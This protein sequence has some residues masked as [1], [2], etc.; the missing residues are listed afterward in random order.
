VRFQDRQAKQAMAQMGCVAAPPRHSRRLKHPFQA[1]AFALPP[2]AC[3]GRDCAPLRRRSSWRRSN[4]A[5]SRSQLRGG[6][7]QPSRL[8]VTHANRH[9][10]T[11]TARAWS[12]VAG[13]DWP[14]GRTSSPAAA[15]RPRVSC[16]PWRGGAPAP[17][18]PRWWPCG[19]GNRGGASERAGLAGR[20]AWC[21]RRGLDAQGPRLGR[22]MKGRGLPHA[23]SSVKAIRPA[24]RPS[25]PERPGRR[26]RPIRERRSPAEA[27]V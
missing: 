23:P 11:G 6:G 5:R 18:C 3:A 4:Q 14:L 21:S 10:Q 22:K 1:G 9:A 19:R 26:P 7:P 8:G 13:A 16:G 15:V 17:F 25:R 20:C 27:E 24:G 12:N 2:G